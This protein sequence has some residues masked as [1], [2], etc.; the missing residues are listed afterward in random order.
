M[1]V[2]SSDPIVLYLTE[3]MHN[4]GLKEI[5]PE[6]KDMSN[7]MISF[8]TLVVYLYSFHTTIK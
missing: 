3:M 5:L 1:I 4:L 6:K 7:T 8:Q 2:T